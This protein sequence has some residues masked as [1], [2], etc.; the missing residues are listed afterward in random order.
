MPLDR[1]TVGALLV[2]EALHDM[3]D[4]RGRYR[5]SEKMGAEAAL[6]RASRARRDPSE[7]RKRQQHMFVGAPSQSLS[8]PLNPSVG[9]SGDLAR[10]GLIKSRRVNGEQCHLISHQKSEPMK[11]MPSHKVHRRCSEERARKWIT[12]CGFWRAG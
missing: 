10:H 12:R 4:D 2:D 5:A 9:T 1:Q 3:R 8:P 7:C 6:T 11:R